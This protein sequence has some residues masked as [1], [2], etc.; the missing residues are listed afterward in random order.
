M[1]V[2]VVSV[3]VELFSGRNLV[4]AVVAVVAAPSYP[5]LPSSVA[6][7][8]SFALRFASRVPVLPPLDVV[9]VLVGLYPFVS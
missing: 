5:P 2:I 9:A 1:V 7:L 3:V 4:A 6:L 8:A